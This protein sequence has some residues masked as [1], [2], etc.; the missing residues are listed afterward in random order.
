MDRLDLYLI[1][2]APTISPKGVVPLADPD[3]DLS[4]QSAF[5]QLAGQ[6]PV[7]A[8]WMVSPLKRCQMTAETLM[9]SGAAAAQVKPDNRLTEQDYGDFH[10]RPVAEVWDEIKDGPKSNWHFLH[11]AFCPPGGES[12]LMLHERAGAV[13][14][15]IEVSATSDL[16]LVGHGMMFRSLIAHALDMPPE[17]A[18][19]LGISPLSLSRLTLIRSGASPDHGNGGRWSL[20]SLNQTFTSAM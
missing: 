16:V 2:H 3:A 13:L 7:S 11:P 12:F 18:L 4:D 19:A 17:Q 5:R 14:Q 9:Q 1:R 8:M 6:L 20:T 10:G 15:S